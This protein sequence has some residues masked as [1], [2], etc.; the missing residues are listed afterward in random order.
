MQSVKSSHLRAEMAMQT[1]PL[2]S[3][4]LSNRVQ[5]HRQKCRL[6]ILEFNRIFLS[7]A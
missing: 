1:C 5:S 6:T 3:L 4:H 7:S 2:S